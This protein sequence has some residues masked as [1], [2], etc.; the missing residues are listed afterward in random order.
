MPAA[1]PLTRDVA[2]LAAVLACL[3]LRWPLVRSAL[4]AAG[5]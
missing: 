1:P 3:P 5:R 2:A 4:A